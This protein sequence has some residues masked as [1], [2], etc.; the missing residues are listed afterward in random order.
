METNYYYCNK[1]HKITQRESNKDRIK[2]FCDTTGKTG[3]ITR[4]KNVDNLAIT[5]SKS[6]MPNLFD[7]SSFS[8]KERLLIYSAFEQGAKVVLN[9][10]S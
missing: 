8:T 6:F 2:S 1:C 3:F 9:G 5:L 10:L 7:F 4:I